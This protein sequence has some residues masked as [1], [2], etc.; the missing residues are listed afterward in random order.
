MKRYAITAK[1]RRY[2]ISVEDDGGPEKIRADFDCG[3]LT[4]AQA[5]VAATELMQAAHVAEFNRMLFPENPDDRRVMTIGK[6]TTDHNERGAPLE[7]LFGVIPFRVVELVAIGI[8]IC[9]F[10]GVVSTILRGS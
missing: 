3:R 5:R 9:V 4:A 6:M 2:S 10:V 8:T 7:P 1:D